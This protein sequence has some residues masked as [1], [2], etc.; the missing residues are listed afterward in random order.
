MKSFD[1]IIVGA[2]PAGSLLGYYLALQKTSVLIIDKKKMP[3]Y[4]SCGGGL[5]KRALDILPFDVSEVIE[6]YPHTVK[7]SLQNH[8]IFQHTSSFPLISMVM[9]DRF[10]Y[11]LIK[12]AISKGVTV[13]AET[14][15]KSVVGKAGNL[16]VETSR[17]AFKTKILVGADG[18]HSKAASALELNINKRQMIGLESEICFEDVKIVNAFM[19]SAC[20]DFGVIPQGYGWI[21]PKKNHLSIGVVSFS[22]KIIE[23]KEYLNRYLETK[24]L[25]KHVMIKFL[26]GWLIPLGPPKNAMV[27]NNKGLLVGDAA[28]LTDPIT[29]EGIFYA[30]KEADIASRVI[31]DTLFGKGSLNVYNEAL[32]ALRNDLTY[33][34]KLQ[35]LLYKIPQISY[36]LMKAYGKRLGKNYVDIITGKTTYYLLYKKIFSVQGIKALFLS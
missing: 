17:G 12:K 31:L 33:A 9:R 22:P 7:I 26:Q 5:T 25:K 23:M 35:R 4:K 6:S 14:K 24:N 34:L 16:S 18:V 10:D 28:G 3:R 15:F 20:F 13:M 29:G 8:I 11:F 21:F 30:L 36:K 19:K 32:E 27:S 1:V 2:G